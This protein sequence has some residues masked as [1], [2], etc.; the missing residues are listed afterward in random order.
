MITH[1]QNLIH[2]QGNSII[3]LEN[4]ALFFNGFIK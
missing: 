1:R 2:P 3:I 4:V